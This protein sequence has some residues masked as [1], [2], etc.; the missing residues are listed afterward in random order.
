MA[1]LCIMEASERES[2]TALMLGKPCG[3]STCLVFDI[4]V[5]CMGNGM[6]HAMWWNPCTDKTREGEP[7]GLNVPKSLSC[8][9]IT[10]KGSMI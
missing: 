1:G 6:Y 3:G 8:R 5:Q 9:G 2:H 7:V 10:C 4:G